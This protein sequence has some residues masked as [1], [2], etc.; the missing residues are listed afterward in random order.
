MNKNQAQSLFELI[1]LAVTESHQA[2][3]DHFACPQDRL[4]SIKRQL[5]PD[6]TNDGQTKTSFQLFQAHLE[7][8]AR[9]V[10]T[11]KEPVTEAQ[12]AKLCELDDLGIVMEVIEAMDNHAQ[13]KK[14]YISAY[15]TIVGWYKIRSTKQNT[16]YHGKQIASNQQSI[17]SSDR[18]KSIIANTL[19][20]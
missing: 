16:T 4:N 7:S 17:S 3:K 8:N 10:L 15:K 5:L 11:M 9:N 12:H 6:Q 13:L 20:Q 19:T 1:E 18:A 2:G 14:K